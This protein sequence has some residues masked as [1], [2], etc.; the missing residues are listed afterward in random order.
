MKLFYSPFHSFIHKVLVT[1][2]EAGLWDDITF[3]ATYPFKNRDGED[4]GDNYSIAAVN[5]LNKVPTL[6]LDDGQVVYASQAMVECLD[7][8][9]TSGKR[10]FPESG[11]LRWDA[12]TRLA[13][14]D[15]IF[16]NT[17]MLAMEGWQPVDKQRIEYFEWIWPKIIRGCDKLEAH[18]K[19]GFDGF[20]IGQASM[21]HAISY[22]D[23]KVNFYEAKDP[24]HPTF[25]IFENRPNLEAWWKETIQRPSVL[26]HYNVDFEG[27]D[28]AAFCQK[29]VQEVLDL[30]KKNGT[31]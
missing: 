13:L 17:V 24:L 4:Q 8:M 2:H 30:Q 5:P 25:N 7:S 14:A 19:R 31:L 20:D 22:M 16:E 21:L 18:C 11:S 23:F 9:R 27:D 10:L 12:I 28:S 26:S 1:V 29:N 15:T 3:V 6:V